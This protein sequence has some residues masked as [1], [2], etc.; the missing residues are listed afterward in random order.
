MGRMLDEGDASTVHAH[1]MEVYAE[2]LRIY[3]AGCSLRWVGQPRDLV[4]GFFADRLSRPAFLDRWRE[5]KRPLR[6]WL[7]VGFKHYLHEEARRM[8][9]AGRA[10]PCENLD[11][12]STDSDKVYDQGCVVQLVRRVLTIAAADCKERGL[13]DHWEIFTMFHFRGLSLHQI[14]EAKGLEPARVAVMKRTATQRFRQIL[15]ELISW[16]GAR[17]PE[18]DDEIRGLIGVLG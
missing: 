9:R 5:S 10:V 11:P 4:A 6:F 8:K 17:D 13:E 15:R 1:V 16:D 18:I 14:A 7:I 12:G 3:C 2:P